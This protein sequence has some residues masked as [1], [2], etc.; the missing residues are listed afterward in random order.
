MNMS[1]SPVTFLGLYG[2]R[3]K[4]PPQIRISGTRC[5]LWAMALFMTCMCACL[6][7]SV[8]TYV[9]VHACVCV[10]VCMCVCAVFVCM[11]LCAF[12]CVYALVCV[13]ERVCAR[14]SVHMCVVR[15]ACIKHDS[16]THPYTCIKYWAHTSRTHARMYTHPHTHARTHIHMYTHLP[17]IL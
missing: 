10:H 8:C 12:V 14:F 2:T 6:R 7:A 11:P 15:C 9:R 17:E 3:G 13:C 1:T 5:L 4:R 16:P